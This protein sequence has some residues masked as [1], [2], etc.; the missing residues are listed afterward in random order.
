MDFDLLKNS[1]PPYIFRTKEAKMQVEIIENIRIGVNVVSHVK[2]K[3]H[4]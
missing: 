1:I 2:T 4:R 3:D